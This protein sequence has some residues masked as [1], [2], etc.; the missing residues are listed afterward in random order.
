VRDQFKEK[1]DDLISDLDNFDVPPS[2]GLYTW[3]KKRV[4]TGH[5]VAKL[6]WF[7]LSI[8]FLPHLDKSY[9]LILP[10][11]GSDHR[12]IS[13]VFESQKIWGPT[14]FRFNPLWMDQTDFISSISQVWN[15]WITDSPIYIWEQELKFVNK[16]LKTWEK[17]SS[18]PI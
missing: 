12:P 15:Q 10:W 5:I 9:S 2:K 7:L 11:E 13:L 18:T 17:T 1:M 14:P 3:N 8:S 16:L 6:D 4:G